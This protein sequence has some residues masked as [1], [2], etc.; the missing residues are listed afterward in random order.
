MARINYFDS[1]KIVYMSTN[2]PFEQRPKISP[3]P[4]C[5]SPSIYQQKPTIDFNP[6]STVL[7]PE[8]K[9][10]LKCISLH[11]WQQLDLNEDAE[12]IHFTATYY[13]KKGNKLLLIGTC[14]Q[15][16]M[17]L[18]SLSGSYI[19]T[20]GQ[21]DDSSKSILMSCLNL[22]TAILSGVYTFFSFTKKGQTYKESA[23]VL[24]YKIEKLKCIIS[25]LLSD[26]EYEDIKR[27]IID[28]LIKHDIECIREKFNKYTFIP[29][30]RSELEHNKV[31]KYNRETNR[32]ELKSIQIESVSR[33]IELEEL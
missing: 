10:E 11:D 24:F 9:A 17:L 16:S 28:T 32:V 1:N 8:M 31:R 33:N 19:A 25:T 15:F 4:G 2:I 7:S 13:T 6:S 23:S 21:F 20:F 22:S 5:L 30:Y 14:I 12:R 3:L 26:K 27:N 18:L 29:L